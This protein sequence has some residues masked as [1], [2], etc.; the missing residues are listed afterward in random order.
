MLRLVASAE[1]GGEALCDL[2]VVDPRTDG[3]G[4]SRAEAIRRHALRRAGANTFSPFRLL[5][6][7]SITRTSIS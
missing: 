1:P 5:I 4:T 3:A 2:A 6:T 7:A